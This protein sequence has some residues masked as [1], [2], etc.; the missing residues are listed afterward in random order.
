MKRW[1]HLVGIMNTFP[2][3]QSMESADGQLRIAERRMAAEAGCPSRQ[4]PSQRTHRYGERSLMD[5]SIFSW[6][7]ML[8]LQVHRFRSDEPTCPRRTLAGLLAP[9]AKEWASRTER[10]RGSLTSG[11]N[12]GQLSASA[13]ACSVVRCTPFAHSSSKATSPSRARS[14]DKQPHF[15]SG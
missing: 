6:P 9:A 2:F 1:R 14:L 11:A 3:L 10:Q 7:V 13:M 15:L 8:R 12:P 5:L 4:R